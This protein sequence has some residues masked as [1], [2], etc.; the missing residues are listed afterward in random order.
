MDWLQGSGTPASDSPR[1]AL[2]C[3]VSSLMLQG[4]FVGRKDSAAHKKEGKLIGKLL[5]L[6]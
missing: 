6:G 4:N 3:S 1:A 5:T 2:N